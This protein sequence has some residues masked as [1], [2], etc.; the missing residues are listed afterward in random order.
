MQVKRITPSQTLL[1]GRPYTPAAST[2]ITKIWRQNGWAPPSRHEQQ[3]AKVKL[4]PLG[5]MP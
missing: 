2:D 1:C 5:V 3:Q 4:N